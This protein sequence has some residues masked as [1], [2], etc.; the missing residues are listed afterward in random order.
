MSCPIPDRLC[1]PDSLTVDVRIQVPEYRRSVMTMTFTVD[2]VPFVRHWK[3]SGI[4]PAPPVGVP[5]PI[6]VVRLID[7]AGGTAH[8]SVRPRPLW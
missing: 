1:A 3:P 2:L 6:P 4:Q 5:T 8:G 7:I